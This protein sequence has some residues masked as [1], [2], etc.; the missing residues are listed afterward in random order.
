MDLIFDVDAAVSKPTQVKLSAVVDEV[1]V[2]V[3]KRGD[4]QFQRCIWDRATPRRYSSCGLK[5]S[6]PTPLRTAYGPHSR[7]ASIRRGTSP[8][9]PAEANTGS[10]ARQIIDKR[11]SVGICMAADSTRRAEESFDS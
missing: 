2:E 4:H 10:E 11:C 9:T 6:V 8:P 3:H 5:V 7:W 1:E